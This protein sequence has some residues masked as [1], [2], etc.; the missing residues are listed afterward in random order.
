MMFTFLRAQ[1]RRHRPLAGRGGPHRDGARGAGEAARARRRAGA[2]GGLHRVDRRRRFGAGQRVATS[3]GSAPTR[4]AST[5]ARRPCERS[6]RR[7]RTR[8]TVLWNGPM[9]IFE[10]PA[11]AAGTLR[12]RAQALA[13]AAAR[14]ATTVV[15]GGDSVAAVQQSGLA[16]AVHA[17]VDRRRRL[18][19]IP[20]GQGPAR[21]RRARRR[22]RAMSPRLAAP[23][24]PG[25]G[26]LEDE[27]H[28]RAE[29][30]ALAREL[31]ELLRAAPGGER[32]DLSAVHR[33]RV[34]GAR[35]LRGTSRPC[36]VART[37]TPSRGRLHRRGLGCHARRSG[38]PIRDRRSLRA[39]AR[40]GG[41]RRAWWRA[42]C[43]RRGATG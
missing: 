42:S 15:G 10:V 36:S 4:W 29:G 41:G 28:A 40:H 22:R 2:A 9:G 24:A 25:R 8:R 32:R 23:P 33:A 27:P 31:V 3:T 12:R 43:A 11:F 19:R 1:G 30:A 17:P 16:R 21:R 20:R 18:A 5:S 7:S 39:P 14:G 13:E 37:C 26:Q 38:L 34:R 35:S 6:P